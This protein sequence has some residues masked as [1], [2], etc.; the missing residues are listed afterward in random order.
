MPGM[1]TEDLQ[2]RDAHSGGQR[3]EAGPDGNMLRIDLRS[4]ADDYFDSPT[5][6]GCFDV[7][8]QCEAGLEIAVRWPQLPSLAGL[9]A[10]RMGEEADGGYP[11]VVHPRGGLDAMASLTDT[12][13]L[14]WRC[15]LGRVALCP[16]VHIKLSGLYDSCASGHDLNRVHLR[17][18]PY[19]RTVMRAFGAERTIVALPRPEEAGWSEEESRMWVEDVLSALDLVALD[20]EFEP[21]SLEE[22]ADLMF[23]KNAAAI[24]GS[25][26]LHDA[27]RTAA[28]A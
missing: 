20:G 2:R 25:G 7:L 26:S 13:G 21:L 12:H 16:D 27:R 1:M 3:A 8:R 14:E 22:A 11:V 24:Y 23:T 4:E 17:A 15:S 18:R 6:H 5:I 19:L 9:L 28:M 10:E